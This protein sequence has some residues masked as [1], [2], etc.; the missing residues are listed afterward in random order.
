MQFRAFVPGIEV[1]GQTLAFMVAGFRILPSTG[2]AYL[3]RFGLTSTDPNGKPFLDPNAWYSQEAWLRCFESVQRDIGD[4]VMFEI[5]KKLGTSAVYPV[6][7]NNLH[8]GVQWLD[9]GY[10]FYH[11]KN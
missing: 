11:R 10:H 8:D 1:S 7:V 2:L 9:R 6:P 4:G 3:A 5:G